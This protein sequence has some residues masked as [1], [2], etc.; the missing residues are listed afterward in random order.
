MA[1][2][3]LEEEAAHPGLGVHHTTPQGWRR[4]VGA[5]SAEVLVSDS[6][7]WPDFGGLG[8]CLGCPRVVVCFLGMQKRL[9]FMVS[10]EL[11]GLVER[12]R[13][14]VARERWLR[15]AV[16]GQLGRDLGGEAPQPSER[17]GF[18]LGATPEIQ[19]AV[20]REMSRSAVPRSHSPNCKCPVCS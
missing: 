8:V 4:G 11:F 9:S 15:R 12:A 20:S 3:D 18:S 1:G 14:D 16:E 7:P 2:Q 17:P 5:R 13:G 19:R 6:L 10:E